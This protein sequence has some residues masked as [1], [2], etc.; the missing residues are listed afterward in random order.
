MKHVVYGYYP[1]YMKYIYIFMFLTLNTKIR[2]VKTQN[3]KHMNRH[4][5]ISLSKI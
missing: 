3:S 2:F 1:I 4:I 5:K